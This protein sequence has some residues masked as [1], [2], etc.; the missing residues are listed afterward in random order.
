MKLWVLSGFGLL[1]LFVLLRVSPIGQ[2]LSIGN[3]NTKSVAHQLPSTGVTILPDLFERG[4]KSGKSF[5]AMDFGDLLTAYEMTGDFRLLERAVESFPDEPEIVIQMAL[6]AVSPDSD[7]LKKLE[8]L[9]P[10]NAL[11]NLIRASLYAEV[12]DLSRFAEEM[13][14]AVSKETVD[15]NLAN[16]LSRI[17]DEMLETGQFP[18]EIIGDG[19][20]GSMDK[21]FSQRSGRIIAT[22]GREKNLLGS[23]D[24]TNALAI[25]WAKKM[26][27]IPGTS[28]LNRDNGTWL[29]AEILKRYNEHDLYGSSG[30]TVG[31]RRVEL[32]AEREDLYLKLVKY[33]E[34]VLTD[35]TDSIL[36]R[37]F[38][39]RVR[40]DGEL[41][42]VD[43]LMTQ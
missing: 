14:V 10:D 4:F 22:L 33:N 8:V 19:T 11:P 3:S 5:N 6:L 23:E 20:L 21:Q 28:L 2:F 12:S 40:A 1:I 41:A 34:L 29:E 36:K 9:Q 43:W 26:Q 13:E 18:H 17:V 35:K 24:A 42:A 38:L 32:K 16:R 25:S 39:S 31:E 30:L 27:D 7:W 37:Q 15:T